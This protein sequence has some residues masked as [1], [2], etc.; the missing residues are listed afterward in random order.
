MHREPEVLEAEA[1]VRKWLDCRA[2]IA[3]NELAPIHSL[4]S[5]ILRSACSTSQKRDAGSGEKCSYARRQV[6]ST[7]WND[8]PRTIQI[9][10]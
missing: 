1:Q 10:M 6:E 7:A 3:S 2:R 4:K 8:L 5:G 9:K